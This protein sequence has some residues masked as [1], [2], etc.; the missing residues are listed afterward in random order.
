MAT[1][2]LRRLVSSRA[3]SAR[4]LDPETLTQLHA[5]LVDERQRLRRQGAPVEQLER[6]RL[7]IVQC[8]WEL[9]RALIAR[10]LPPVAA[11]NAA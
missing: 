9:S 5:T 2:A 10:N 6:N 1:P 7:A 4:Q 11:P 3:F 8:Q